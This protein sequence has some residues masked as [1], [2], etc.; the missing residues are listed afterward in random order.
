VRDYF[1]KM[2]A[3]IRKQHIIFRKIVRKIFCKIALANVT[4]YHK[5]LKIMWKHEKRM[6]IELH[7]SKC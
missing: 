4:C 1:K 2:F 7:M 6:K 3:L 5:F